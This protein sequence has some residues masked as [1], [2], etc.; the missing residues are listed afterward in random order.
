MDLYSMHRIEVNRKKICLVRLPEGYFAIDNKCPHAGGSLSF[1]KCDSEGVVT[2]PVHRYQ[3]DAKTGKGL[4]G[5][6]V[7]S[8]PVEITEDGMYIGFK[9]NW[10]MFRENIY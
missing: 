6:Y 4:Q 10:W 5:D 9:S 2:C 1:G 7:N 8:Y 3:F